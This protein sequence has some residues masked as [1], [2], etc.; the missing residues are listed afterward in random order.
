MK[1]GEIE[2]RVVKEKAAETQTFFAFLFASSVSTGQEKKKKSLDQ[3]IWTSKSAYHNLIGH[4]GLSRT[5][6]CDKA[7]SFYIT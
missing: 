2:C 3:K 1:K 6:T 7:Y 5:V 4:R